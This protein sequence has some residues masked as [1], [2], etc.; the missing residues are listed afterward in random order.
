MDTMAD[1]LSNV[2]RCLRSYHVFSAK[3]L[4]S[5]TS[6]FSIKNTCFVAVILKSYC[7]ESFTQMYRVEVTLHEQI[8]DLL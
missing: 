3:V 1:Q 5:S 7:D 6:F 8:L 2:E 4:K